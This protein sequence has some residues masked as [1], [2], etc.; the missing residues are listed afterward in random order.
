MH[1]LSQQEIIVLGILRVA[2]EIRLRKPDAKIVIN[3]L[4]PMIDFQT[5]QQPKMSD[6]ADF[7]RDKD[8]AGRESIEVKNAKEKFAR[9][10]AAEE[11]AKGAAKGVDPEQRRLQKGLTPEQKK[12]MTPEQKKKAQSMTEAQRQAWMKNHNEQTGKKMEGGKQWDKKKKRGK[13]DDDATEGPAL[14]KAMDRRKKKLDKKDKHDRNKVFKDDETYH[15]KKPV[16]P[17]IPLIK[18]SVLPPVWPE[19]HMINEKLKEF[20]SK[21]EAITFFDA[22]PTF[23]TYEGSGGHLLKNELISPRGHPSELGFAVWEADIM[24]TLQKML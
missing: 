12:K 11:A 1:S 18:E 10:K 24:G 8:N 5:M 13:D 22:T 14:E 23:A 20:C 6:F 15:P 21:H 17:F 19:V 4:L 7:K 16:A 3:S 2:E 9:A